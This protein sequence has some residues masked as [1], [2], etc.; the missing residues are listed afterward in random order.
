MKIEVFLFYLKK[1]II[2]QFLS[3]NVLQSWINLKSNTIFSLYFV[4]SMLTDPKRDVNADA[5]PKPQWWQWQ[6]LLK[7]THVACLWTL[8]HVKETSQGGGINGL[9]HVIRFHTVVV[10]ATTTV[11]GK[12]IG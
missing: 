10:V 3:I 7:L 8:D 2:L 11:S 6:A 1:V 9:A 5:P 12:F 4:S